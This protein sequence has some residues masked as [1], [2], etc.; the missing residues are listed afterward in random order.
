MQKNLLL[1][2]AFR[3]EEN[4]FEKLWTYVE[5]SSAE[6]KR[7][8][9][10]CLVSWQCDNLCNNKVQT[11][12]DMLYGNGENASPSWTACFAE[13]CWE[14]KPTAPLWIKVR[15]TLCHGWVENSDHNDVM[16]QHTVYVYTYV[17]IYIHI[18]WYSYVC[19]FIMCTYVYRL[20]FFLVAMLEVWGW[21]HRVQYDRQ[22]QQGGHLHPKL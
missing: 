8:I 5:Q 19:T 22:H 3:P 18:C 14:Q 2:L 21:Q 6:R 17:Y 9:A 10:T 7:H 13:L 20:M 12:A 1:E 16:M 15:M 11:N 4:V